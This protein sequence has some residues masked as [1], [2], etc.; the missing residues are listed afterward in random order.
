MHLNVIKCY[1]N[2]ILIFS[3]VWDEMKSTS[4]EVLVLATLF[5]V[6]FVICTELLILSFYIT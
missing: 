3:R 1:F 5:S 4:I 2:L 6:V